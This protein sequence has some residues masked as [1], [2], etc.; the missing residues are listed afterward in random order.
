MEKRHVKCRVCKKEIILQNYK[1]HIRSQHENED[2]HDLRPYSQTSLQS[3]FNKSSVS[4]AKK[5]KNLWRILETER[6][7]RDK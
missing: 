3:I 6:M 2:C 4:G 7:A 1:E 5:T